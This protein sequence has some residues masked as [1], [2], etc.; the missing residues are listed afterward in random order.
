MCRKI[1]CCIQTFDMLQPK[2]INRNPCLVGK[3]IKQTVEHA[4][5]VVNNAVIQI[6]YK[7]NTFEEDSINLQKWHL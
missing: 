3:I 2:E 4:F 1:R 6:L 7:T 5:L